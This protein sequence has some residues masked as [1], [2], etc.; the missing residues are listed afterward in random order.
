VI[1]GKSSIGAAI[2][3]CQNVASRVGRH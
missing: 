2:E 3:N 1:A